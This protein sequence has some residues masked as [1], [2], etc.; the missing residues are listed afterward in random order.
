MRSLIGLMSHVLADNT[1]GYVH[2]S[3]YAC[4][5][6]ASHIG[7]ERQFYTYHIAE[8][9]THKGHVYKTIVVDLETGRIV[10]VGEGHGKS[11]SITNRVGKLQFIELT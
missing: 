6:M 10:Y 4:P 1:D 9:A 7:S 8:F 5:R 2:I 11:G 3:G